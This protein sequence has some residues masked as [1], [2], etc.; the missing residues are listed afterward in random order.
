MS[1]RT[2]FTE[3]QCARA[4]RLREG[5][6]TYQEIADRMGST[7]ST[8]HKLAKRGFRRH[9]FGDR[10]C[11]GD[12]SLRISEMTFNECKRFY[13]VSHITLNRWIAEKGLTLPQRHRATPKRPCPTDF[14]EIAPTM[15]HVELQRHYRTCGYIIVRWKRECGISTPRSD[16]IASKKAGARSFD[17]AERYYAERIAA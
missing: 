10:P 4:K 3:E 2:W 8:I 14:A 6:Y 7:K 5:G 13:R 12:L 17:W 11:P 9:T 16:Y 15:T 1:K